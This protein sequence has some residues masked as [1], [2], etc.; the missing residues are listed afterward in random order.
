[1]VGCIR[2]T[3]SLVGQDAG[4]EARA[5]VETADVG[6][7]PAPVAT[8]GLPTAAA[9]SCDPYCQTGTCNWCSEKCTISG[10]D[11][12]VGCAKINGG[13]TRGSGCKI[14]NQGSSS[15]YDNCD[16]GFICMGDYASAV[17]NT[18]CFQL[19]QSAADCSAVACTLR[20]VAPGANPPTARV[21]DPD[22]ETCSGTISPSY[23]C[24][25]PTTG[26]GCAL[27]EICYLVP[28]IDSATKDNRT[29]CE[30]WSGGGRKGDTCISSTDCEV[31]LFCSSE[32]CLQA[33]DV[34]AA[35]PCG[36][37]GTCVGFGGNQFGYCQ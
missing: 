30:Y 29:V 10:Y 11:G 12:T 24:C 36:S 19:C 26:A 22:Y 27:Q 16:R 2:A 33:C 4:P 32:H 37:G 25:D 3:F 8:C 6:G 13:G 1:M 35:S 7:C 18:H 20:P 31:G 17:P 14:S 21:C 15:E 34:N 9:T 28:Q 5:D 23:G